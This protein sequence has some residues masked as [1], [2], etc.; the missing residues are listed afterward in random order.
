MP[1]PVLRKK[2][3]VS[4]IVQVEIEPTAGGGGV[5]TGAITFMAKKK[6]LGTAVLSGGRGT[7]TVKAASVLQKSITVSYAGD[8]DFTSSTTSSPVLTQKSIA[9]SIRPATAFLR[10]KPALSRIAHPVPLGSR[11]IISR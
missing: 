11:V 8:S 10:A 2:K 7:L 1:V 3:L 9:K 5:P 4:I 6:K